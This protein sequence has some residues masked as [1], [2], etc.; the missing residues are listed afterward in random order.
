MRRLDVLRFPSPIGELHFSI[1]FCFSF[2]LPVSYCFRPLSGSYISQWGFQ[3]LQKEEQTCFRPLSGSYIS[4]YFAW[5]N[6]PF[7]IVSV[8]YRGATFLNG[9]KRPTVDSFTK[10]QF[11]SPIGEL[12]F[13]ITHLWTQKKSSM[14]FPSPIGELH[15]SINGKMYRFTNAPF[16]FRP[17]SGSYISQYG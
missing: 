16:C 10:E 1:F 6:H 15:F 13:S 4:Q 9:T 14:T 3:I 17:L 11:P 12:H 8:P 5:F 2:P 7:S